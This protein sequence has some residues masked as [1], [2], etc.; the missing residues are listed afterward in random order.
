MPKLSNLFIIRSLIIL[1]ALG[2]VLFE[3]TNRIRALS[4]IKQDGQVLLLKLRPVDPR[5]FMM[6]DYMALAYHSQAFPNSNQAKDYPPQGMV[7]LKR[8]ENNVGIFERF[9]EGE[10]LADDEV[11][12][13]YAHRKGLVDFG[14]KRYYFQEGTARLYEPADYGVFKVSPSGYMVLSGLADKN[15]QIIR[16][17]TYNNDDKNQPNKED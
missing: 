4:K 16:P 11:K 8:D 2:F 7:V 5:A 12:V 10:T 1:A 15:Y 17:K 13:R 6:G 14:S 3:Y 9:Y